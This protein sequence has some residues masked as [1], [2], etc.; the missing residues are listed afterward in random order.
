MLDQ[1]DCYCYF[2]LDGHSSH[3]N[4]N[5]VEMARENDVIIFTLVPHTTHEMQSLDTAVFGPLINNWQE[6]CHTFILEE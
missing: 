4:L 6:A 1:A 2:S 3:Y 5:I